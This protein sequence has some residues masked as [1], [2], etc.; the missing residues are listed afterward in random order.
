M[1]RKLVKQGASTL[2]VS[3][4]AKWAR[5]HKLDKGSE[6]EVE[7]DNNTLRI[8][9]A[10]KSDSKEIKLQLIENN[11]KDIK[12]ILTHAYR[13]GF[14]KIK[15]E[16]VNKEAIREIQQIVDKMLLGFEI[17]MRSNNECVVENVSEPSNKKYQDLLKRALSI[18]KETHISIV[19]DIKSGKYESSLEIE[20]MK[21]HI[22]KLILFCRR[23]LLKEPEQDVALN[24]ELLT[25]LTHISH[26]YYYLYNYSKTRQFKTDKNT[27]DLLESLEKYY[28]M[29][30]DAIINKNISSVHKINSLKE[31]YHFGKIPKM[32]EKSLGKK[33][34]VLMHLNELFRLIQISSSPVLSIILNK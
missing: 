7:E 10:G 20:E 25:F 11:K 12:N 22:D 5:E 16:G 2:M 23:V 8:V 19:E 4:P 9:A 28:A 6:V 17:T 15:I 1:K 29:L 30:E 34:V 14:E 26:K 18:I 3:I 27:L 13:R 32:L 31:E 33:T 24:W 21:E